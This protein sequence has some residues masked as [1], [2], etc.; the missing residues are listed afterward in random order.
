MQNYPNELWKRDKHAG[1]GSD[2]LK[3]NA[4]LHSPLS[5]VAELVSELSSAL[6]DDPLIDELAFLP[7]AGP[8]DVFG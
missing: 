7:S 3:P 5:V 2:R 8:S 1:D 4:T 6:V